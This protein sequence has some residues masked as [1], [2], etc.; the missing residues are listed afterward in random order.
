MTGQPDTEARQALLALEDGPK[1]AE[2][3]KRPK[4]GPRKRDTVQNSVESASG[5]GRKSFKQLSLL[6]TSGLARLTDIAEQAI[7]SP[8]TAK[9]QNI[10][11][12]N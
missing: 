12:S 4:D 3:Q 11:E 10:N 8:S 1:T 5:E 7:Q 2:E 6:D 9:N